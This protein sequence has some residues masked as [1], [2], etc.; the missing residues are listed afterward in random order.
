[1]KLETLLGSL[2]VDQWVTKQAVV[3]DWFDGPREGVCSLAR[4]GGEFYF[5]LLDERPN[6]EDLD[7][8]LF[9]LSELAPGSVTEV[10]TATRELGQPTGPVWVPMW[11]FPNETAQ[12]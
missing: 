2:P 3:F 8:R 11:R 4:P 6:A 7:D 9:R 12:Q 5:E 1:M 10:L